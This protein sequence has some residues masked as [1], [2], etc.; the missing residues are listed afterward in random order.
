[1]TLMAVLRAPPELL[2]EQ[3]TL[4]LPSPQSHHCITTTVTFSDPVTHLPAPARSEGYHSHLFPSATPSLTTPQLT[5]RREP[6]PT[7]VPGPCPE[8]LLH[9]Y[10]F[11]FPLQALYSPVA[12][13][14]VWRQGW[15]QGWALPISSFSC[16]GIKEQALGVIILPANGSTDPTPQCECYKGRK[17][18]RQWRGWFVL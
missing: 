6:K 7:M 11:F 1:M 14:S 2:S 17:S 9:C 12:M 10:N 18:R 16:K 4:S 5:G 8:C 3:G 13:C 15:A